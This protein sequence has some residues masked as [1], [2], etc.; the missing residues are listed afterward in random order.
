MYKE[1]KDGS[2]QDE[3]D[4]TEKKN[5]I[6]DGLAKDYIDLNNKFTHLS[7]C[8]ECTRNMM[9]YFAGVTIGIIIASY[10]RGD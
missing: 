4:G 8:H 5:T 2:I 3:E 7:K 9:F 10:L 1:Q 6:D